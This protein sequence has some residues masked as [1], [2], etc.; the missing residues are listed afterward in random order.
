MKSALLVIDI[1]NLVVEGKPFAIEERLQLWQDSLALVRQSGIEVIY[2]RHH[3]QELVKDTPDWEIHPL[4]APLENEMIFDK[5]FNSAFKETGLH[6]YLQKQKINKLIIMGMATNFCVDTTVKVAFEYGY[7]LA[8][9][10]DG[11]TTGYT[12]KMD[13]KDL[14][15]HYQNIWSWNFAQVDTLENILR[16]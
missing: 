13:A 3:D 10:K 1:Q 6:S 2:I 4:V 16:G 7:Q 9:I 12:G 8:I 5:T 11:T 14:I 15:D